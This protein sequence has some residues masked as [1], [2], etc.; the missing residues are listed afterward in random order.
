MRDEVSE[1]R[2]VLAGTG[3]TRQ[4]VLPGPDEV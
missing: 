3:S 4:Q 1:T 2:E